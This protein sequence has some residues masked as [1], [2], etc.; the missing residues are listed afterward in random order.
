VGG[1]QR[2]A[3]L[4]SFHSKYYPFL[5]PKGRKKKEGERVGAQEGKGKGR[6]MLTKGA[7]FDAL[8]LMASTGERGR[9]EKGER[10]GIGEKKGKGKKG[11]SSC[12]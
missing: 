6:A 10:E 2:E 7:A 9:G 1:G 4:C 5:G 12:Y 3:I 8:S 11:V